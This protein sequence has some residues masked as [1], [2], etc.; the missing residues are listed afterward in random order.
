MPTLY[1][2]LLDVGNVPSEKLHNLLH[3][4]NTV[5]NLSMLFYGLN[6]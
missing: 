3:K 6:N 5:Y 2:L 1:V 4:N